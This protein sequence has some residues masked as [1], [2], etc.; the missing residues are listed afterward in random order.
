MSPLVPPT[1]IA[2]GDGHV[3]LIALTMTRRKGRPVRPPRSRFLGKFAGG[4][5]GKGLVGVNGAARQFR[6]DPLRS[7]PV[8]LRDQHRLPGGHCDARHRAVS[9]VSRDH[10]RALATVW[11]P[12]R[13]LYDRPAPH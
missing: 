5:V 2:L 1:A 6:H 9:G 8:L 7:R 10:E 12:E 4:S 13:L 3:P 11:E